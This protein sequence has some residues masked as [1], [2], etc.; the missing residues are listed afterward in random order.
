MLR[1]LNVAITVTDIKSLKDM[2]IVKET[3]QECTHTFDLNAW[4]WIIR[5]YRIANGLQKRLTKEY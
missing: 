1:L 4:L 2:H 3:V 5:I